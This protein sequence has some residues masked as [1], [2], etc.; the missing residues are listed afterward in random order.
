M[1]LT[2]E[3][4]WVY[5]MIHHQWLYRQATNCIFKSAFSKHGRRVMNNPARVSSNSETG[6]YG[7]PNN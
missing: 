7:V 5:D 3:K 4:K 6:T 2:E 1:S